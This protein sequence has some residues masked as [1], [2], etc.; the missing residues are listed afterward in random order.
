MCLI[1]EQ[2]LLSSFRCY[3][4]QTLK[5]FLPLRSF[6]VVFIFRLMALLHCF[7][8]NLLLFWG[9]P[10]HGFCCSCEDF[11]KFALY[12]LPHGFVVLEFI[13]CSFEWNCHVTVAF[14]RYMILSCTLERGSST[15]DLTF[16]VIHTD[17]PALL[18]IEDSKALGVLTLNADFI[19]KCST[20][21]TPLTGKPGDCSRF[22]RRTAPSSAGYFKSNLA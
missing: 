8:V 17:Q 1:G 3:T 6:K 10:K 16:Q 4:R 20:S 21:T 14:T 22:R 9:K 12:V 18:S 5:F 2:N 19:R 13:C 11:T 15:F 7:L